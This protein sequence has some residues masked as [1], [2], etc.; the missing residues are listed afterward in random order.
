MAVM[1]PHN[2]ISIAGQP[3]LRLIINMSTPT[4]TSTR[5]FHNFRSAEHQ[6][7]RAK[8]DVM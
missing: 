2:R 8:K 6:L 4:S 3:G 5:F 1:L 7:L